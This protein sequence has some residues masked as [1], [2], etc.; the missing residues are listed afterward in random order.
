MSN[1]W[2]TALTALGGG[3][4][5]GTFSLAGGYLQ[6]RLNRSDVQVR[7]ERE[8]QQVAEAGVLAG[9]K[10]A[11]EAVM[12]GVEAM[13]RQWTDESKSS[14]Y[15][16]ESRRV[17]RLWDLHEEVRV[18]GLTLEARLRA[19]VATAAHVLRFAGEI[20][21]N[22]V[23]RGGFIFL[24]PAGVAKAAHEAIYEELTRF[25][26]GDGRVPWPDDALRVVA[27]RA[28]LLRVRAEMY[29]SEQIE[30]KTDRE[31][32]D[33]THPGWNSRREAAAG[34]SEMDAR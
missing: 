27:A 18:A 12:S 5:G 3:L 14:G 8:R 29:E 31:D 23:R 34:A 6:S 2:V 32:F 21:G 11:A 28:D 4:I 20:G 15:A 22:E 25:I 30:Y 17:S 7:E 9:Q 33:A 24:G 1:A 16:G 10:A 13:R 19:N 26:A